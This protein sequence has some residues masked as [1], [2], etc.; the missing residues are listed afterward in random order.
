MA[1]QL[2]WMGWI[3]PYAL[4]K[5]ERLS[6]DGFSEN[7]EKS[8]EGILLIWCVCG[9]ITLHIFVCM[10]CY[11]CTAWEQAKLCQQRGCPAVNDDFGRVAP[12]CSFSLIPFALG[13]VRTCNAMMNASLNLHVSTWHLLTFPDLPKSH[14]WLQQSL[15]QLTPLPDLCFWIDS[16]ICCLGISLS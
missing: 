15:T 14:W 10:A 2:M 1:W 11:S 4:F 8:L 12:P 16:S 7:L 3:Y 9:F 13:G 6:F 5:P